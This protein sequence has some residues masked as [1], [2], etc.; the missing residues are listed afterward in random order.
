MTSDTAAAREYLNLTKDPVRPGGLSSQEIAELRKLGWTNV[1][2]PTDVH[3]HVQFKDAA[4]LY[5]RDGWVKAG[6]EVFSRR[7]NAAGVFHDFEMVGGC[8]NVMVRR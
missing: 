6:T 8:G 2:L 3:A 7:S 5:Y 1:E 4:G